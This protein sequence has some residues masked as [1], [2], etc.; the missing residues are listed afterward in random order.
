MTD[1]LTA[2]D[3]IDLDREWKGRASS[4][5]EADA[6]ALVALYDGQSRTVVYEFLA[7]LRLGDKD[8]KA[9]PAPNLCR[10]LVDQLAL[11]YRTPPTRRLMAGAEVLPDADPRAVAVARAYRAAHIDTA[12][13]RADVLRACVRQSA[14]VL[15]EDHRLRR[16]GLRVYAPQHVYRVPRL[17]AADVVD[18]DQAVALRL[19]PNA[20]EVW[21]QTKDGTWRVSIEDTEGA[22]AGEQPYADTD[23][24]APYDSPPIV[25]TYDEDPLGRAWLA[26]DQ[27]RLDTLLNVSAMYCDLAYL[28]AL[29]TFTLKV[30]IG[31][32]AYKMQKEVGP[33]KIITLPAGADF[34]ML[35]H[36]AQIGDAVLV[37]QAVLSALALAEGLAPNAFSKD[38]AELSGAAL[39]AADRLLDARRVAQIPLAEAAEVELFRK[40]AAVHNTYASE[41][42]VPP[43]DAGLE[44][45]VTFPEPSVP[46]DAEQ[47]QR[48]AFNDLQAG[49][50]SPVAYVQR[51]YGLPRDRALELIQSVADDRELLGWTRHAQPPGAVAG[52]PNAGLGPGSATMD[53]TATNIDGASNNE[54]ASVVG[55]LARNAAP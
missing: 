9:P 46:T 27:A 35:A 31:V 49:L 3:I 7:T 11:T 4:T 5:F 41:W 6:D 40:L 32:D 47:E 2:G 21:Q 50:L 53:P 54:Q 16:V 8:N 14:V 23:G 25:L 30:A 19:G 12:M 55:S 44:L 22:P 29:E 36:S 28:V 17:T 13:R 48:V 34:K 43:I 20:F 45:A 33:N 38:R 1:L 24:I 51:R 15:A 10:R 26:P 42:E 18:Q 37:S 52:G 39:R